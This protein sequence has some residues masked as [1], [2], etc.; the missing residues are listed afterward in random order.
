ML[1]LVL[2]HLIWMTL[3]SHRNRLVDTCSKHLTCSCSTFWK[4]H[5]EKTWNSYFWYVILFDFDILRTLTSDLSLRILTLLS[6]QYTCRQ[7]LVYGYCRLS[8]IISAFW[9]FYI[10]VRSP[11]RSTPIQ[12]THNTLL[13]IDSFKVWLIILFETNWSFS[14]L[15]VWSHCVCRNSASFV[16]AIWCSSGYICCQTHPRCEGLVPI[17]S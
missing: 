17:V 9:T 10:R 3:N 15:S 13:Q 5:L 12:Y 1:G 8:D 16:W 14:V 6:V 7:W 11:T 4:F 2:F